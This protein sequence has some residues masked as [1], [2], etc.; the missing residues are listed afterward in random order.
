MVRRY[1]GSGFRAAVALYPVCDY[2]PR[3]TLAAPLLVL[4]GADDNWTGAAPCDRGIKGLAGAGQPAAT[5]ARTRVAAFL[6]SAMK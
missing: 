1:H 2:M 4:L 6:T 3:R 5:D